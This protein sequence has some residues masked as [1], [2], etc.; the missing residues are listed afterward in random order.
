MD[1]A[2]RQS[3][4]RHA[5]TMVLADFDLA[6]EDDDLHAVEVQES[7]ID[8]RSPLYL[9]GKML[10]S[11]VQRGGLHNALLWPS[12]MQGVDRWVLVQGSM[13]SIDMELDGH[14]ARWFADPVTAMLIVQWRRDGHRLPAE[15][16]PEE[17]FAAYGRTEIDKDGRRGQLLVEDAG[18]AWRMHL[19]GLLLAHAQGRAPGVSVSHE[20]WFRIIHGDVVPGEVLKPV[21]DKR[22]NEKKYNIILDPLI[23]AASDALNPTRSIF[24]SGVNL[25]KSKIKRIVL[26]N[27]SNISLIGN[28]KFKL[29]NTLVDWCK[30][31]IRSERGRNGKGYSIST[32]RG[33]FDCLVSMFIG[34]HHEFNPLTIPWLTLEEYVKSFL[35]NEKRHQHR[36]K[37]I[38]AFQSF[39]RFLY[40]CRGSEPID[41][42]LD[43]Y[44]LEDPISADLLLPEEYDRLIRLLDRTKQEQIA[45]VVILLFRTGL[46][47]TEAVGLRCGDFASAGD[48]LELFVE[49][50]EERVL[51]TPGSRRII[52]LDILLESEELARLQRFLKAQRT[53]T[54]EGRDGWLFGTADSATAPNSAF[55]SSAINDALKRASA[56][57]LEHGHLRHSFASYL[58]ATLMLPVDMAEPPVPRRLT[59][60]ISQQRRERVA[61]RLLGAER[62][63]ASALHAVSQV[64]GHSG[65]DMTLRSYIHLLDWLLGLYCARPS[66]FD[67]LE[68]ELLQE[69]TK[70]KPDAWRKRKGRLKRSDALQCPPLPCRPTASQLLSYT[71]QMDAKRAEISLLQSALKKASKSLA[72]DFTSRSA[73]P[74]PENFGRPA[75]FTAEEKQLPTSPQAI[76]KPRSKKR[77]RD[78]LAPHA[79]PARNMIDLFSG[80][81]QAGNGK[82]VYWRRASNSLLPVGFWQG[83]KGQLLLSPLTKDP[84]YLKALESRLSLSRKVGAREAR[85]LETALTAMLQNTRSNEFLFRNLKDREIFVNLLLKAMGFKEADIHLRHTCKLYPMR[86]SATLHLFLKSRDVIPPL[87]GRSRWRGS[88]AV[89][90]EQK[91]RKSLQDDRAFKLAIV[92]L[93]IHV[94]AE[95]LAADALARPTSQRRLALIVKL[96]RE[97]NGRA[98][99]EVG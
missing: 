80:N 85:V 79:I 60:V 19:P 74:L 53:K 77:A 5:V 17:C 41:F 49:K 48:R 12:W 64:M 46:R 42:G 35:A 50:N 44:R 69:L 88:L 70:V 43:E 45:L 71:P 36:N 10:T 58:L 54:I 38:N 65:P 16:T 89:R 20:S 7:A 95:Q 63:G 94:R 21:Q 27:L 93:A 56:R 23:L 84:A 59:S 1:S 39:G 73:R 37:C 14:S 87:K 82:H 24:K 32:V 25:K 76:H 86:N 11:A 78:W 72:V 2:C 98:M 47:L 30:Y 55:A 62:L 15:A 61:Q 68:P 91:E 28:D 96:F 52:P 40:N 90:L 8:V 26:N 66:S 75:T 31:A 83:K 33:Y 29:Q 34:W 99:Q 57:E 81:A 3:R 22:K 18:R 9:M 51:K 97:M 92:L 4:D 13:L 67:V 6:Y